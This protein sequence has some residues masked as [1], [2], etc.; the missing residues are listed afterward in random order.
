MMCHSSV[1]IF[2]FAGPLAGSVAQAFFDE[3]GLLPAMNRVSSIPIMPWSDA[4]FVGILQRN[5]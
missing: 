1:L 2:S 4:S 3:L 5:L